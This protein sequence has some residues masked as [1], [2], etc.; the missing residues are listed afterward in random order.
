MYVLLIMSESYAKQMAEKG[1]GE[2]RVINVLDKGEG[3]R[4]RE[5]GQTRVEGDSPDQ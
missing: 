2:G 1:D 4:E 5:R 3:G